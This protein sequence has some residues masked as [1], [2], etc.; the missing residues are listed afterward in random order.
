MHIYLTFLENHRTKTLGLPA[1]DYANSEIIDKKL[2][3][4]KCTLVAPYIRP[5]NPFRRSFTHLARGG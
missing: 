4:I 3:A 5:A 2:V 1:L